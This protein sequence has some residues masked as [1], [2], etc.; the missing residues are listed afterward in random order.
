VAVPV[1]IDAPGNPY[2]GD[3]PDPQFYELYLLDGNDRITIS[4]IG[5]YHVSL[6]SGNDTAEVI[7]PHYGTAFVAA[8]GDRGN[9]VIR[10]GANHDR[11]YGG[12]DDDVLVGNGGQDELSG[13]QGFDDLYGGDDEDFLYGGEGFDELMGEAGDDWL[14]GGGG[15]DALRGGAGKDRMAGD[16]GDDAYE[17]TEKGDRVLEHAKEGHDTVFSS[18]RFK[19]GLNVEDLILFGTDAISGTGNSLGNGMRGNAANNVLKGLGGRDNLNGDLGKD[20]L[21]G[22]TGKDYF[23][24][25][26]MGAANADKIMDF[27][28]KDDTILLERTVFAGIADADWTPLTK[29]QFWASRS[30]QAH[31]GNDR[32]LYDTTDGK[33]YWDPDGKGGQARQHFAT[34]DKHPGV[35]AADFIIV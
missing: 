24:F 28:S 23:S 7:G 10:G 32:I 25:H 3:F 22:G 1:F 19:L 35:G 29:A 21:F 13:D 15:N 27:K 33:L 14:Y 17:V 18:I 11:M 26:L 4:G 31:D 8:Y 16:D 30:G 5:G 34:L 2:V 9:D 12:L 20:K 6:G